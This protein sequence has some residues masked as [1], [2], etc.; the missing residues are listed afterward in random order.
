MKHG[1]M[2]GVFLAG[3]IALV[4]HGSGALAEVKGALVK[5]N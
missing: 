2:I 4:V 1:V 5:I 3:L